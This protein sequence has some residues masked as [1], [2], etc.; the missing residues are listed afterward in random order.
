M[1]NIILESKILRGAIQMK[2]T[3]RDEKAGALRTQD[4]IPGIMY[5]HGIEST[6]VQVPRKEFI[7]TYDKCKQTRTFNCEIDQVTHQVYIKEIQRDILRPDLI[8][9]F[10]ILKVSSTDKIH[11]RLPIVL[12]GRENIERQGLIVQQSLNDIEVKY[13]V[14][15]GLESIEINVAS[16]KDGDNIKVS[17]IVVPDYVEVLEDM[18]NLVAAIYKPRVEAEPVEEEVLV[19]PTPTK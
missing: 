14:G 9:H 3:I 13:L 5:G 4:V 1:G 18:D 6:K 16:Y 19:A 12:L 15:K 17:D 11:T 2:L 10:D 8:T 7:K